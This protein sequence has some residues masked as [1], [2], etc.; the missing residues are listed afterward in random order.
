MSLFRAL[1]LLP[2][3][4]C[5]AGSPGPEVGSVSYGGETY[6]IHARADD[7]AVWRM[8]ADGQTVLCRA[9]TEADCYWSLRN[10]LAS[11]A[12]LDDQEA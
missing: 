12:A 1:V 2:V 11:R 4:A 8:E 9:A 3:A 10:F 5:A 7:P 6:A